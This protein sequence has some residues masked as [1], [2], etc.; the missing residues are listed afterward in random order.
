MSKYDHVRRALKGPTGRHTCHWPGCATLVSP[1]V[2]GCR[3]H[4]YM[5]PKEIRDAI[6]GAYRAGQELDKCPST[7]YL[8]AARAAQKWIVTQGGQ[9]EVPR[10]DLRLPEAD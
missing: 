10:L 4:W 6:W 2:W 8:A 9:N 3:G 1:A 7:E 5:L